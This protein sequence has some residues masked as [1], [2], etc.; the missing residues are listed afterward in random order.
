MTT[1]EIKLLLEKYKNNE[2][3]EEECL[4]LLR[5]VTD[6]THAEALKADILATLSSQVPDA[7]WEEDGMLV[8]IFQ[9]GKESESAFQ[10]GKQRSRKRAYMALAA[11]LTGGMIIV[12][13]YTLPEKKHIVTAQV[14]H[15]KLTPGSDKA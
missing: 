4:R 1:S 11:V 15:H 12:G 6:D 3:S 2:I 5:E 13:I 7:G 9:H 14:V 10:V 8:S